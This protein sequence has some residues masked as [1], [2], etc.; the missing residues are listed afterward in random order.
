M[1]IAIFTDYYLPSLGGT[2]TAIFHQ[3]RALEARGHEVIIVTVNYPE[4]RRNKGFILLPS[5]VRIKQGSTYMRGFVPV[6]SIEQLVVSKLRRWGVDVVHVETEFSVGALGCRVAKRLKVPCVYTAHTLIWLQSEIASIEQLGF[7]SALTQLGMTVYLPG[8]RRR[9][10]KL[11]GESPAHYVFR[12]LA[13]NYAEYATIV[14]SPSQHLKDDLVNWGVKTPIVV[15]PNFCDAAPDRKPLPKKPMFLWAGR[16]DPEKRPLDFVTALLELE[17]LCPSNSFDV[18]MIGTGEQLAA[19]KRE[20]GNKSWLAHVGFLSYT[21]MPEVIGNSS[22]IVLTSQNFDNQPMIIAEAVLQ[23]RGVVLV[24]KKL[25]EGL[26]GGA[27]LWTDGKT[28]HDLTLT[29]KRIVDEPKLV[30]QMSDAAWNN[31]TVFT[32]EH[33]GH[34]LEKIYQRAL[35]LHEDTLEQS[36][37]HR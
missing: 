32:A 16:M 31:S 30:E 7:L 6:P 37:I 1:K 21:H 34:E 18:M 26:G 2:Q 11:P 3:K 15:Q 25:K 20:I 9:V 8:K 12:K 10:T 35:Q 33:G 36:N 22:V 4:W 14:A 28:P 23:A 27:G 19:V 5:P 13:V 17:T 24:D 29:L